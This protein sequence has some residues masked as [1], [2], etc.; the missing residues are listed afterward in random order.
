MRKKACEVK[1]MIKNAVR[2]DE[3]FKGGSV[4]AIEEFINTALSIRS[5]PFYAINRKSDQKYEYCKVHNLLHKKILKLV[6][7]PHDHPRSQ[8]AAENDPL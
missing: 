1:E 3:D 4:K 2:E 5:M 7:Q 8:K 6:R